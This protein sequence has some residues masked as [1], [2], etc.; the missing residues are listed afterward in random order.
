MSSAGAVF[1][2]GEAYELVMG[3]WSRQVG[4]SFK[5]WMDVPPGLRW[6]DIGCGN[7][8]FNVLILARLVPS[9]HVGLHPSPGTIDHA[10]HRPAAQHIDLQ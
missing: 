5:D 1:S 10:H 9:N 4:E 6:E 8:P 7:G 3:R 2:D